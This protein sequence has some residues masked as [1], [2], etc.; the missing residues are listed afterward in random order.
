M[1]PS[2]NTPKQPNSEQH[3]QQPQ[4][5]VAN[6]MKPPPITYQVWD[7]D[8]VYNYLNTKLEGKYR[9]TLLSNVDLKPNVDTSENYRT[10]S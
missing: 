9:I 7:Y 4:Q 5:E 3:Q 8:I 1:D 2:C 10:A 6:Y